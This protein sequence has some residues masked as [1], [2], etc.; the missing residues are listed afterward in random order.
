[1]EKSTARFLVLGCT[2][3]FVS[4]LQ[5]LDIAIFGV[6]PN[7]LLVVIVT[8]ALFL[9]DFLHELFLLS[10]ASFLLKFSPV[11]NREILAFFFIGLIIILIERKLPW[12]TL[13]NGIFLTFFA[14]IALYVFVDRA[15]IASLMFAK[16]LGYNVLLTYALYHGF[17]FFR[18]FRHR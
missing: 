9:R 18:L 6:V 17:V 12:H 13:V 4:V 14:T 5:F 16:E 1:M 8:M 3:L 2:L 10:L 11:V 7:M 15:S